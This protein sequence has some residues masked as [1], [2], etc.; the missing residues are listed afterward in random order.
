[1][2]HK[3]STAVPPFYNEAGGYHASQLF[4]EEAAFQLIAAERARK[5]QPFLCPQDRILEIGVGTGLDLAALHCAERFGYDVGSHLRSQV[6]WR[7]IRFSDSLD[8]LPAQHFD[9]ILCHHVLEHVPDPMAMLHSVIRL[10][11]PD[12]KLLLHVP[13]EKER[14]YRRYRS[15]E[16]NHH[17]YSWNPQTIGNLVSAAGFTLQSV[18]LDSYGYERFAAKYLASAGESFYRAALA[19]LR[20]IRPVSEIRIVAVR[21]G[22]A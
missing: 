18:R 7:G 3:V 2:P 9:A 4:V 5:I 15:D 20:A 14:R 17:L 19:M 12:G 6:E 8:S 13:Y 16:P 11:R 1:M 21:G 22:G 10:L